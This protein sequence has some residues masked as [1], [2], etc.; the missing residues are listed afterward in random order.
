MSMGKKIIKGKQLETR[1]S[2]EEKVH[3]LPV[4]ERGRKMVEELGGVVNRRILDAE[5]RA[6]EIVAE[7]EA[8]ADCI[9]EEAARL[10]REVDAVRTSAEDEGRRSGREEG[11][12]SA[13]EM[14]ARLGRLKEEFIAHAEPEVI[15]L[16]LQC[17]EKIVGRLVERE[18]EAVIAIVR[19]AL[20]AA[21]GDRIVIRVSPA[22][23]PTVASAEGE[24]RSL[25]DRT[26]RLH[27]KE[28]ESI[29]AGGCV[30]ETE[31]GTIDAQLETQLKAIRKAFDL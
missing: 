5:S 3:A 11:L 24:L 25:L 23:F 4:K 22:D 27:V 29:T 18:K 2:L 15:A 14:A 1:T 19:Q 16:V 9:R 7:A 12:A 26:K 21:I 31:V 13:T 17:A 20:E 8:S 30:V 10:L 6:A 28:D